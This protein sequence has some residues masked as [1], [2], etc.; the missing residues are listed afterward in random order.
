MPLTP[1]KASVEKMIKTAEQ[2]AANPGE[3]R[4]K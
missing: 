2:G 1:L 3:R 4:E